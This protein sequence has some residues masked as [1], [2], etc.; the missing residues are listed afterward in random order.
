[1]LKLI[2]ALRYHVRIMDYVSEQQQDLCVYA[3][4]FT[5]VQLVWFKWILV[6]L[7][8]ALQATRW[9]VRVTIMKHTIASVERV[10]LV[11]LVRKRQTHVHCYHHHVK[12]V[13]LV[14]IQSMVIVVN[15]TVRIR[16]VIAVFPSIHVQVI[17]VFHQVLSHVKQWR[18]QQ[19]MISLV[20]VNEV[21]RVSARKWFSQGESFLVGRLCDTVLAPCDSGPCSFGTCIAI[22]T[23]WRCVCAPGWTGIQCK[24]AIN[25]CLSNPCL[26]AGVCVDGINEYRCICLTGFTGA[27]CQTVVNPCDSLPCRNGGK[28]SLTGANDFDRYASRRQLCK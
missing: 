18:M 19:I 1:M 10:S 16:A 4:R 23:T 26:N 5:P 24:D 8:H 11:W 25:E 28:T 15:A 17:H 12:M 3:L 9:I 13:E 27:N 14:S 20:H 21:I 6:S 22:G 7:N 2:F